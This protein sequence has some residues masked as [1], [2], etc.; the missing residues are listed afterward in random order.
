MN[1]FDGQNR[2]VAVFLLKALSVYVLWF[3]LYDLWLLPDGRLDLHISRNIVAVT[4]GMLQ[5]AGF[6]VFTFDRIVG[7]GSANGLEIIDGCNG[8]E[9][10]GLF[11]GF[12]LAFPGDRIKRWMFIPAGILV[13]YLV[14]VIRIFV[15]SIVQYY[16]YPGFQ[17]IHDYTFN[18]I[19]YLVVFGLWVI[20]AWY[21][22]SSHKINDADPESNS[23]TV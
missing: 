13:L 22:D 1:W 14:N 18:L 6:D 4:G 17:F 19:F 3:L 16:W 10:I 11:L 2:V 12:V 7:I 21:G 9:T 5:F 15:L 8:L 20:W 23:T